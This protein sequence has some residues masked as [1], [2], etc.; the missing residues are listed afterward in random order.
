MTVKLVPTFVKLVKSNKN[1]S[2]L[3]KKKQGGRRLDGT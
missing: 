1:H 3:Y 2:Q